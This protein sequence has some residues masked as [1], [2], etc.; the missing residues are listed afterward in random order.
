MRAPGSC[1]LP[2]A[3]LWGDT[4][5]LCIFETTIQSR[6][7]SSTKPPSPHNLCKLLPMVID[8]YSELYTTSDITPEDH[9]TALNFLSSNLDERLTADEI[10]DLLTPFTDEEL[11]DATSSKAIFKRLHCSRP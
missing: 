4:G 8:F 1:D 11:H 2:P 3:Q 5:Q 7:S 10:H 6:F 9:Q